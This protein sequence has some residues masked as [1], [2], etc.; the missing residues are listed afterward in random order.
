MIS[1]CVLDQPIL[2]Q[3]DDGQIDNEVWV[4]SYLQILLFIIATVSLLSF[5]PILFLQSRCLDVVMDIAKEIRFIMQLN[6]LTSV[7]GFKVSIKMC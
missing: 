1:V 2:N 5:R 7:S 6:Y 4:H 3:Q